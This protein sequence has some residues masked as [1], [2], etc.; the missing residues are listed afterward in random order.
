MK[1]LDDVL[2]KFDDK[3]GSDNNDIDDDMSTRCRMQSMESADVDNKSDLFVQCSIEEGLSMV[4]A[5]AMACG[6]PKSK[7]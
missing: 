5:Q 3:F 1:K 6:I 4:L 2:C 7:K